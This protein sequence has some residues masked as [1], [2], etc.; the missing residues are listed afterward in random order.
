MTW[1]LVSSLSAVLALERVSME[2][3]G[4]VETSQGSLSEKDRW[5]CTVFLHGDRERWNLLLPLSVMWKGSVSCR[6]H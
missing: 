5:G 6:S 1:G 4:T 3:L 2:S